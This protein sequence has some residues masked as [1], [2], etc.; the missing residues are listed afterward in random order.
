MADAYGDERAEGDQNA[1]DHADND[2]WPAIGW[3]GC[4]VPFPSFG[5][6]HW[7]AILASCRLEAR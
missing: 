4:G 1:G 7:W 2:H 5:W 3:L 6:R